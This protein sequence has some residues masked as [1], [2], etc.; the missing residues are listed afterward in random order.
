MRLITTPVPTPRTAHSRLNHRPLA[1]DRS[2][3]GLTTTRWTATWWTQEREDRCSLRTWATIKVSKPSI[4]AQWQTTELWRFHRIWTT[5]TLVK[6]SSWASHQPKTSANH[7]PCHRYPTLSSRRSS[8][9]QWSNPRISRNSRPWLSLPIC[10]TNCAK[11]S[12]LCKKRDLAVK[13]NCSA[14]WWT[15]WLPASSW[16]P[17]KNTEMRLWNSS[18][19]R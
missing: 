9:K 5:S 10:S 19:Q 11:P 18:D 15:R 16:R 7:K 8:S 6:A 3:P 1:P 13:S 12:S 17:A 2:Q 14:A 4:P